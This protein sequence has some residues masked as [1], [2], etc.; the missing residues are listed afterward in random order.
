[1]IA[2]APGGFLIPAGAQTRLQAR[3][4]DFLFTGDSLQADNGAVQFYWCSVGPPA[5]SYLF[6][7]VKSSVK[8]G[9]AR[10]ALPNRTS[11]DECVLPALE[12]NPEV[13][14]VPAL[15][16]VARGAANLASVPAAI[17]AYTGRNRSRLETLS[18]ADL[19]DPRRR[20]LLATAL[21][22]AGLLREAAAEYLELAST[23]KSQP[24][25]VKYALDLE[26]PGPAI[27]SLIQPPLQRP[28]DGKGAV[29][30]LV[31]G[32]SIYERPGIPN[33][34]F[35]D[36]DAEEFARYLRTDRGGAQDVVLLTNQDARVARIRNE[37]LALLSRMK[38][39]D[40]LVV[41][42]AS[43]G[44]MQND[45]PRIV[46][47]RA[48]SQEPA[49]NAMPLTEIQKYMFGES[50]PY[51]EARI[52]LDVCHSGDIALLQPPQ[53]RSQGSPKNPASHNLMAV[54]D[55]FALTATHQGRTAYAYEDELFDKHG[56]F[57]YFLLRG[58]NSRDASNG[59]RMLTNAALGN[60]VVNHVF[61][62]TNN[63]QYP[64]LSLETDLNHVIAD[65]GLRGLP[66]FDNR[67]YEKLLLPR[68]S[69]ERLTGRRA[70]QG[71]Q[72]APPPDPPQGSSEMDRR[73]ALEDQGEAI[74]L[75]YLD[76]DEAPQKKP[77]FE[78]CAGIF[79]R[80]LSLQPGSPYL[81]ARRDF[82]QGRAQ[83]FDKQYSD[84]IGN[85]ESS[86]RLDPTAAYG[87]NALGIAYLEQG[88][89]QNASLAFQ[90]AILRAPKWAYPRH[91][92]ALAY[93]ED[94]DFDRAV[95]TYQ[96]AMALAPDYFYL[97]YNL[98]LLYQRMNRPVE[99]AAEYEIARS[100]APNRAE[101]MTAAAM[102]M[103]SQPG[104]RAE[105][106]ALLRQAK[107]MVNQETTAI[108]AARHDLGVLLAADAATRDEAVALWRQNGSYPS[109]Q[110]SLAET[111]ERLNHTSEAA[112]TY[113]EILQDHP[114]HTSARLQLA[115]LLE[116][117]GQAPDAVDELNRGLRYLPENAVILEALGKASALA[118]RPSDARRFY[119][120]ALKQTTDPATRKRIR[121]YLR[122]L[123][124]PA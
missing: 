84:A 87:Y 70:V 64:A 88:D 123:N 82:C 118:H 54:P 93:T 30:A 23:W 12:R 19:I 69:L 50:A 41:F 124:K 38:D 29:H 20:L 6:R 10:P 48:N 2:A 31:I 117:M 73:V 114:D 94:G 11:I 115:A 106:I 92:L 67:P 105:A 74:L 60:Y 81:E 55:F 14:T 83:I 68:E 96:D 107:G 78:D 58:L 16:E 45:M 103:A 108:Q 95:R 8:I 9:P 122:D 34:K 65:L 90:D 85:L 62:A 1:V 97:R 24:R 42:V 25:L 91:N 44:D 13:A 53:H 98:G 15:S 102:L 111:L 46:T 17:Q 71:K 79:S 27:R 110:L 33:L 61:A 49:I 100:R 32:I 80:A 63:Q 101:P 22:Q 99:A 109:S 47:Y 57:T 77:S 56:V 40:A 35:A 37:F 5:E 39:N 104:K 3:A 43:H 18:E 4:G 7:L 121:K 113:R 59:E 36:R 66:S 76:G 86:I 116:Q 28:P 112:Q 26:H 89:Y 75:H 72:E 51:K 21:E 52:F 119:Q 120:R